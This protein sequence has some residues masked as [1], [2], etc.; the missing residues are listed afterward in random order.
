MSLKSVEVLFSGEPTIVYINQGPAGDSFSAPISTT[1]DTNLTGYIYGNGAKIGGATPG[2]ASA[3]AST[4]AI[5]DGSGNLAAGAFLLPNGSNTGTIDNA[6]LTANRTYTMPN[7]SGYVALTTNANGVVT[8]SEVYAKA[9]EAI[10]AGNAVYVSGASGSNKII[11]LSQANTDSL[12]S[13]TLGLSLQNL[14]TNQFGYVVT[15]GDITGL[16]INLGSGH[17]VVEGDPIWLSPTTPGGLLYGV[18][19]KPSAPNHLVF[20]GVV[21]RINGNTLTDIFVKVQNGFELE[22]LHN[23]QISSP[24]D[25]QVL[26]YDLA[27]D[28]WKNADPQGGDGSITTSTT[29]NLA[30]FIYGNGA[31]ISTAVEGTESPNADTI[32]IRDDSGRIN[33]YQL[34]LHGGQYYSQLN[35]APNPA[36]NVSFDFPN[37]SGV[38]ATNN[39]AVMLTGAQSVSGA[40][41]FNNNVQLLNQVATDPSAAI[42]YGAADS[43]YTSLIRG[44]ST[45]QVITTSLDLVNVTSIDLGIG[46]Y[47]VE[48]YAATFTTAGTTNTTIR[49][50]GTAGQTIDFSGRDEYGSRTL[51]TTVDL[52]SFNLDSTA[53]QSVGTDSNFYRYMR[54]II[55]LTTN[56]T[57]RIQIRRSSAATLN[58]ITCRKGAYITATKI[59]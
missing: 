37:T 4:M 7:A 12:S 19:N 18:A 53:R 52:E 24:S 41:S 22:E 16:S 43:R 39:T 47:L 45:A 3:T 26:T 51:S 17:T 5:R 49:I 55:T 57:L 29:T 40:K 59:A 44:Y 36:S 56:V 23:V 9:G 38:I 31:N 6:T 42:T 48:A 25:G 14:T 11:S 1:T 50:A 35:F 58:T 27:T 32:V 20:I 2:S 10:S 28:L 46:T 33:A 54:G 21:T 15:E 8:N 30:G 34:R 13:K